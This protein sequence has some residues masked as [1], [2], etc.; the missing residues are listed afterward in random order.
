VSS[1][2]GFTLIEVMMSV[3]II[4]IL[5]GLSAPVYETFVRRNDLDLVTQNIAST[6]RRAEAYARSGNGD[7]DWSVEIQTS[8][9]TLFQGTNFAGRNTNFDETVAIPTSVTRSGLSEVQF[10]KF[11][12]A[13]NTSGTITLTSTT[14]STRTITINAQGMVD[15]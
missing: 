13:P 15:Y 7:A 11:T 1:Q 4:A 8:T 2:G 3:T 6:L 14:S 12:S 5:V 10:T 9:A